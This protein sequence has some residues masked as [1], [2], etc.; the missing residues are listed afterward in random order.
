MRLIRLFKHDLAR[1]ILEWTEKGL[2]TPDQAQAICSTYGMDLDTISRHRRAYWLLILLGYLFLGLAVITLVSANWDQ[3]PRGVRMGG[4]ILITLFTQGTGLYSHTRGRETA[5][6]GLFF[7]GSLFYG[8]SIMLIAQIYHIGEHFPDGTLAWA[9]GVLPLA[10]ILKSRALMLLAAGLGSIWFFQ[11]AALGY[12]PWLFPLFLGAAAWH[13]IKSGSCKILF[14]MLIV[15]TGL[16]CELSLS[17]FLGGWDHLD[18]DLENLFFAFGYGLFCYGLGR[19]LDSRERPDFKD[20]ASL[21]TAWALR[22]F[23]L[24]LFIFSF[25]APWEEILVQPWQMPGTALAAAV[26]ISLA[27]LA[28][29]WAGRTAG[30]SPLAPGLAVLLYLGTMAA[31][32]LISDR[33]AALW[34]S[35][36]DNLILIISGVWLIVEG[37]RKGIS[38]YFFLGVV[39][40][41]ALGLIRYLDLVGDYVGAAALFT[42]FAVILLVTARLWRPRVKT[43]TAEEDKA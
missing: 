13:L 2:I 26:V 32:V 6:T 36:A 27:A 42:V 8:I 15:L 18:F 7:L 30:H 21:I 29:C 31:T 17:W 5:A 23:V 34:F 10:I 22:L 41:L 1:E 37:V 24:S 16:F 38:H 39:V 20:Y 14:S 33:D 43:A 28:L 19:F 3:I 4:L 12:F 40:I 9:L 35:V 25:E 11:E